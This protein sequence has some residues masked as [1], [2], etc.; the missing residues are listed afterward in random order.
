MKWI[1][2]KEKMPK[3]GKWVLV[4]DQFGGFRQISTAQW[5]GEEWMDYLLSKHDYSDAITHWMP[6]PKPPTRAS[7]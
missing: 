2:V 6:L 7:G 1:S 5:D 3:K 4:Y